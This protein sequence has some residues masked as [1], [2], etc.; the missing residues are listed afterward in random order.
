MVA[1]GMYVETGSGWFS[2]RTSCYLATG[3]PAVVQD[4]GILELYPT[5]EG[6]LAFSTVDEAVARVE[7]VAAD[8]RRHARA[9]RELAEQVFDS[10]L[11]LSELLER[12][13]A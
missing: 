12:I 13:A 8:Y 3:R 11:V 2:D 9:A 5:G 10:D 1:K 6:L 4:T 7:A